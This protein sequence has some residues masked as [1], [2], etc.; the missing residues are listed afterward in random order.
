MS[1]PLRIAVASSGLG[2]IA[3]GIETWASDLGHALHQRGHDVRLYQGG[4]TPP[5]YGEVL[6]NLP[7][8]SAENARWGNRLPA[9]L[10]WRIGATAGYALEQ[11]SFAWS[12][13][14]ALRRRPADILHVQDP[15]LALRLDQLRRAGL[16]QTRTILAHGT[17]E[18][19]SFLS[20]FRYLQHLS[21]T[22]LERCRAEG[23]WRPTWTAIGNFVDCDR[24]HPGAAAGVR[25]ALGI[26]A[27]AQVVLT[28][29]AIKRPHKRI[30]WL[31]SAMA[32]YRARHPEVPFVLVVAGGREADTDEIIREGTALLGDQVRFL[33]RHPRAEIAD[34][35]RAADV[36][37][38]ASL[39]EMMPIALLEAAATGLPCLIHDEATLRWMT[40]AGGVPTRMDDVDAMLPALHGLLADPVARATVAAAARAHAVAEFS[41]ESI[42]QRYLAYYAA[43]MADRP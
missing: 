29:A 33:V 17:E 3:R 30:D 31:L 9:A 32:A 18:P 13:A 4:G 24:F 34:L 21:P 27:N 40:G 11:S 35:C 38:L 8:E 6:R 14:K 25:T 15:L 23:V 7:R 2:H 20:R 12:L 16:L 36:F 22:Q 28:L 26:P 39:F 10:A 41:E 5:S 37:V 1:A 43:V 19:P 42:V